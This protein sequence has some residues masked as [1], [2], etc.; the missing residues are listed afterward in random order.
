M[1]HLQNMAKVMLV[2]GLIVAYGYMTEAFIAW[3]S[4]DKY[5]G[6]VPMNRMFGPY[7][8]LLLGADP[9]QRRH[10]AAAVVQAGAHQRAERC[11]SSR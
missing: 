10:P 11:S 2:T 3:Y 1:R 5:E 7:A 9:L 8:R 6:F 4:G